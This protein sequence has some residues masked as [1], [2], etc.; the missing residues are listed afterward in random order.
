[1][2]AP[3][4]TTRDA[5]L[6]IVVGAIHADG[7]VVPAEVREAELQLRGVPSLDIAPEDVTARLPD[8]RAALHREGAS[9]FLDACVA[10]LP[11]ALRMRAFAAVSEVIVAD[12]EILPAEERY[13][14]KL[15]T[16]FRVVE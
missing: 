4:L 2:R 12:R 6:G 13:L 1:M 8:V 11:P 15:A 10:S 16:S 7:K 5:L 9:A 14:S 3:L